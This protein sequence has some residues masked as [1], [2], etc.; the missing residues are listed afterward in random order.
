MRRKPFILA[1]SCIAR[2]T[3][4]S[5][6]VYVSGLLLAAHCAHNKQNNNVWAKSEIDF[7]FTMLL[8]SSFIHSVIASAGAENAFVNIALRLV[9]VM[10]RAK[11]FE[12]KIVFYHGEY[13]VGVVF[14]RCLFFFFFSLFLLLKM[15]KATT[16][17]RI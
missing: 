8:F 15:H 6:Y 11:Y 4:R 5:L 1:P 2:Y 3:I 9:Y 13:N 14:F 16:R 17:R 12:R 7:L 10:E